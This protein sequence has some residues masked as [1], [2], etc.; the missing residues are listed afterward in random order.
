[1]TTRSLASPAAIAYGAQQLFPLELIH[2][3]IAEAEQLLR[4]LEVGDPI[5]GP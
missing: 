3:K 2:A 5:D 1:M 4:L